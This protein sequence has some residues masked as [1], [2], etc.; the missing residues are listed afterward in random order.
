MEFLKDVKEL[1]SELRTIHGE[2]VSP[3]KPSLWRLIYN[4]VAV[5]LEY[6][7]NLNLEKKQA[8]ENSGV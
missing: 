5:Y 2:D 6:I 1:I 7:K 8:L 4:G 3:D